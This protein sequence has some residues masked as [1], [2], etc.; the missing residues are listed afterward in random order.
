M[1]NIKDLPQDIYRVLEGGKLSDAGIKQFADKLAALLHSRFDGSEPS[2]AP[3]LR[4]SNLGQPCERK[5]YYDIHQSE[6]KEPLTGQTL[7]KFLYG[8]LIELLVLF[9]AAEA[10]H[11]VKGEQAE[12]EINGV[13]GHRDAIVDGVMSDVKSASGRGFDKFK[14]HAL[15]RDD[16]FGYLTQLGGY[17]AASQ[18]DP[19]LQVKKQA[20]FIAVNKENGEIAVD[21]YDFDTDLDKWNETVTS[22]REMLGSDK[23]PLRGF[24]PVAEGAQGNMRLGVNCSYCN[25]K[26]TCWPGL[27]TFLYSKGPVHLTKVIKEPNVP[28]LRSD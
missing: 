28:E 12:V 1:P 21:L 2:K 17:L 10:G 18:E 3:T 26:S 7:L 25:H 24:N 20:A 13:P 16:P 23:P 14:Y 11:S 6:N 5:L 19:D 22:K 4:M 8:D 9:L 27:R 15:E